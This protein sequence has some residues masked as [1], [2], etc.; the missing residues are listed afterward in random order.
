MKDAK[1]ASPLSTENKEPALVA[2]SRERPKRPERKALNDP[3]RLKFKNLDPNYH[4]Y[5]IA[6]DKEHNGNKM[7]DFIENYWE[8]VTRSELYGSDCHSPDEHIGVN[9][10]AKLR[11]MKLPMEYHLEDEARRQSERD[12]VIKQV[13][14]KAGEFGGMTSDFK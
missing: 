1:E 8:P 5:M 9:D 7:Q 12:E 4:Y 3:G 13:K 10:N 2:S 11:L 14:E 6:T